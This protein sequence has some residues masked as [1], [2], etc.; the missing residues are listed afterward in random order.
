MA[1]G[2][3][4]THESGLLDLL[5]TSVDWG[6]TAYYAVLATTTNAPNRA[7]WINYEDII[8]EHAATGNYDQVALAFTG[9]SAVVDGT[10]ILFKCDKINFG[11][12]TT[13]SARYLYIL[14]GSAAAPG[15]SDLILGH[16]DLDGAGN[17]SSVGAEFSFTPNAANGL[18]RVSRSAAA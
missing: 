1:V 9:G 11:S 17:I 5:S 2:P 14:K 6:T 10:D 8:N 3:F 4:N 7:T 13:I 16:V 12:N 15:A 18:F